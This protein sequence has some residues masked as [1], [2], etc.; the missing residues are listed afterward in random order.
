[1]ATHANQNVPVVR[2]KLQ[3]LD[4][5]S[6]KATLCEVH[7]NILFLVGTAK[8]PDGCCSVYLL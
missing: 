4:K 6:L 7:S 8:L 2:D 3:L 5:Q 1:M